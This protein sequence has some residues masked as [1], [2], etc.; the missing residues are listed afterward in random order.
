M[1]TLFSRTRFGDRYLVTGLTDW[2]P[3]VGIYLV[4]LF[5]LPNRA[6]YSQ[7]RDID[8]ARLQSIVS[9]VMIYAAFEFF[10]LLVAQTVLKRKINVSPIFQL[11]FVL[12]RQWE[13]VQLKLVLWLVFVLNMSLEHFGKWHLHVST[14][15]IIVKL[16]F[17]RCCYFVGVDYTFQFAWLHSQSA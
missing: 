16:E 12:E 7:L 2:L 14:R 10:S 11:G 9:N 1:V 15:P 5:H 8:A 6:F 4:V 13:L 3:V 17:L